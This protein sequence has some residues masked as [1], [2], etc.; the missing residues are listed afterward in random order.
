MEMDLLKAVVL[1]WELYLPR[2]HSG[3]FWK[4]YGWSYWRE[5][6]LGARHQ[7]CCFRSYKAH[8]ITCHKELAQNISGF[9][10]SAPCSPYHSPLHKHL[11]SI[12]FLL[13]LENLHIQAR[14]LY[15]SAPGGWVRSLKGWHTGDRTWWRGVSEVSDCH[16]G[17]TSL[18]QQC[19]YSLTPDSV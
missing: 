13:S 7:R 15:F 17:L 5:Q 2:Q 6:E 3:R 9:P 19:Y 12:A 18:S 16:P 8:R 4:Q 1:R 11:F 10:T 14:G